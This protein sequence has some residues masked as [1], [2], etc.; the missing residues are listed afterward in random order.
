MR[1]KR[2]LFVTE[3]HKLA[4]GFGTY[5]KE[6]IQRIYDTG[7]YEIAQMACY[8]S[9]DK[10]ENTDWLIYGISPLP[11]EKEYAKH[12]SN[13]N[14]QWGI[15]RFESIC[16]DFKPDIVAC[17][18][19]PW[20]D[21]YIADSPFLPFFHWVWMPTIDSEPQK[22]EWLYWFDKCD[23]LLAYSEYGIRT[24]EKETN[25]RVV[26]A[27][28]ASPGIDSSLFNI[29]PNKEAHKAKY[30]IPED[31]FV[32]GTVMRNQKR[33]MFPDLMRAFKQFLDESDPVTASKSYLYLH[34]SYPEKMGWNITSLIH[35]FGIGSNVLVT[36]VCKHCK[37][38]F[39]SG[40][41][42]ALTVCDHCN[43]NAAVLPGVGFGI[44]QEELPNIYNLMDLYVQYAICEGFGM[45]QV[46]AASCGVPVASI[47][48]SAMEDVVRFTEGHIIE[49][50]LQRE[51][52]TNADRSGA[53]NNRLVEI[54]KS[55]SKMNKDNAKKKRL[56]VRA[57]C[58]K[59]YSWD[60]AAESWEKYFDS[61]VP[62]G[63]EGQWNY[64]P[65]LKE[66]PSEPLKGLNNVQFCEWL[67][68]DVIQ[69]TNEIYG[70]KMLTTL[71][72]LNFGAK[73]GMGN[74]SNYNQDIAF[75]EA[76]SIGN[77]RYQYDFL[78]TN[79]NQQQPLLFIQEAKRRMKNDR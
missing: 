67:F 22:P 50:R 20:M 59:R 9:P 58:I 47:D 74:L 52:E 19:D 26:P 43:R 62:K 25:G 24:L 27:G 32:V 4:S 28:C 11:Q 64:R 68:R 70:Y 23:G 48:Y 79:P 21:A 76:V 69:D 77:R 61:V 75:Q 33:K 16:L 40:Y 44:E 55:C 10:F 30:G 15:T 49:P 31:S 12:H 3:S 71:R 60:N 1:K 34:T 35:E 78:R 72:D 29:I 45:P 2:I 14:V 66:P 65:L 73:F 7:K 6:V 42:D 39:C 63:L 57:A 38:H 46:E 36:Y 51:L 8:S 53:N 18:R 17:Y 13:P 41:R 54:L 5:A 37:K 56:Q